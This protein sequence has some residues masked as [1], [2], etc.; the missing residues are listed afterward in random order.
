[1]STAYVIGWWARHL[2]AN[3]VQQQNLHE[4]ERIDQTV[5]DQKDILGKNRRATDRTVAHLWAN[6][7][8]L[9]LW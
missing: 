1:M 8:D 5:V 3:T 2:G 9:N 4:L 6:M 7:V